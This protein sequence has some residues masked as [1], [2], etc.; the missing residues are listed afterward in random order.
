MRSRT[1]RPCRAWRHHRGLVGGRPVRVRQRRRSRHQ[2][3]HARA[4]R[5]PIHRRLGHEFEQGTQADG[6]ADEIPVFCA[7]PGRLCAAGR[8]ERLCDRRQPHRRHQR[9]G[10][11]AAAG[12]RVTL[13]ITS[14]GPTPRS[15]TR[16]WAPL[17]SGSHISPANTDPVDLAHVA[18]RKPRPLAGA[19]LVHHPNGETRAAPAA[20]G[21]CTVRP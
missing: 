15:G 18:A 20:C 2:P 19:R 5:R 7:R 1:G 21:Q 8:A 16:A 17:P 13:A 10:A 6:R 9:A 4:G 14:E 3:H 12:H 11:A